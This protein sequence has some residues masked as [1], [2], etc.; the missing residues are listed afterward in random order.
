MSEESNRKRSIALKGIPKNYIRM[1]GKTHSSETL[2]K[3][4]KPKKDKSKYQTEEFKNL[5]RDKQAKAARER[6]VMSKEQYD[7]MQSLISSGLSKKKI[8]EMLCL[9]YDIIK[10]WSKLPWD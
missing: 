9:N 8:S 3:M 7:N 2:H 4:R 6:R 10:K 5:M 1:H